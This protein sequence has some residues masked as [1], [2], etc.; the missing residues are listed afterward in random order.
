MTDDWAADSRHRPFEDF[1]PEVHRD[2]HR[3]I[4]PLLETA[5]P[6]EQR[7]VGSFAFAHGVVKMLEHSPLMIIAPWELNAKPRPLREQEAAERDAERRDA[8]REALERR[9]HR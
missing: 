4:Q 5:T 6:A 3:V 7:R 1:L 2:I 8:I 9:P